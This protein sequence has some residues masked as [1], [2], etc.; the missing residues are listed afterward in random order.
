MRSRLCVT[1]SLLAPWAAS[2]AAQAPQ[3]TPAPP[4][5]TETLQVTATRIPEDVDQVPASIQ[6]ITTEEL[7]DRGA[8]DLKSAL[9]LISGVDIAPGGDN[10]PASSVPEFWGLK[11][12]DAFLLVVDGV[13]W[14]GAFN[15]A[16]GTL[17]LSD[18]DHIEVQRGPGAVLYGATSLVGVIQIVRRAPGAKGGHVSVTGGSYET[19]GAAFSVRVPTWLAFDSSLSGSFDRQGFKDDRTSFKKGHLL[20]RNR[21][22]WG[23]SSF[24]FD[25][26][27]TWLRQ[28]PASPT[29]RQGPALTSAVPLDSNQNPLGA[30]LD[31]NRTFVNVGYD[32]GLS[33][34]SWTTTLAFTHSGQEQ[35]RGFLTGVSSD[36]PNAAGFGANID[37]ND[38]YFDT[39]V[40]WTKASTWK[41]VAGIDY[42]F[43]K[44][45]AK[46]DSFDYGVN[47]DGSDPPSVAFPSEDRHIDDTRN[48]AGLYGNLEWNPAASWRIDAGL[49]LNR[50]AEERGEGDVAEEAAG[51]DE[52]KREDT[53]PSG[54]VG[55]TWTAWRHDD[56]L[57]SVFANWK[58]TFKPAAIDFNF[59]EEGE[60]EGILKPES[61]NSY[62]AGLKTEL[63]GK[64]LRLELAGFLMDFKNLVIAQ[65]IGGLPSLTNAGNSRLKGVEL[66]AVWKVVPHV[67]ARG[68]YSY[69]DARFRDYLTEF[70]GVPTQLAGKRLEMSPHHLGAL[71]LS[72]APPHGLFASAEMSYVGTRFLNKR[73]TAPADA[74][75]TVA[76]LVGFRQGRWEL[77]ASGRNITDRRD[78]VAESELG[79]AQYYRLF[80]R[81]FD[82]L[83]TVHF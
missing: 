55:L 77:R 70:D 29:P 61:T 78:P 35:F 81:R 69:H 5:Y 80:P 8:T 24:H 66:S 39:H 11:E 3:P 63:L 36:V 60:G 76:A 49:R 45:E 51:G 58:N 7:R 10:G 72:W 37:Q 22:T 16:L 20:W 57:L 26:D 42:L 75:A 21:R 17:D 13:P 74:Y 83:V 62:E 6:V 59:A 50:T 79:D 38:L 9:A 41:A 82:A 19:G 14:G 54:G 18:V 2:A 46:G 65:S 44:A 47:L 1:V 52:A 43:G 32:R 56:G 64:A 40:T 31:E 48:F 15:P 28:E 25:I 33:F 30:R 23:Q 68:S 67:F 27:G 73:N 12:F 53:R 4:A 34:G 71:A